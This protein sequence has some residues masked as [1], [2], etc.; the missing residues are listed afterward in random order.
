MRKRCGTV[1]ARDAARHMGVKI[2]LLIKVWCAYQ[3]ILVQLYNS[4]ILTL[5]FPHT[6]IPYQRAQLYPGV[7]LIL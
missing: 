5:I 4:L 7:Y 1:D 6:G 2:R 3:V